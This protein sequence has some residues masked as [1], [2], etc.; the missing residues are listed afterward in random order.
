MTAVAVRA[1]RANNSAWPCSV[2]RGEAINVWN[3]LNLDTRA[4]ESGD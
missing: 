2:I 4:Q 1:V 3:K